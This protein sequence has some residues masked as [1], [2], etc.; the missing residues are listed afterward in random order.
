MIDRLVVAVRALAALT[1]TVVPR[2][3]VADGADA[4]RLVLD[5]PQQ[6]LTPAQRRALRGLGDV[7]DD[8]RA[9]VDA[10]VHAA[11]ATCAA[12]GWSCPP[13]A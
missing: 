1:T 7:L 12:L 11:R 6:E 2:D 8:E 3:L 5:C 10:L 9:S 4:V 13:R